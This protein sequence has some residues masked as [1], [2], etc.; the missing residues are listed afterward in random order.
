MLPFLC[1]QVCHA[2]EDVYATATVQYIWPHGQTSKPARKRKERRNEQTGEMRDASC[3]GFHRLLFAL[4][5]DR[6]KIENAK[7]LQVVGVEG[8]VDEDRVVSQFMQVGE[9]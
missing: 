5:S 6:S 3:V 9:E 8:V 4:L 1:V 7:G 2:D